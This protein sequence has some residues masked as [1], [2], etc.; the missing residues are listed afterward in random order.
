MFKTRLKE[1]RDDESEG[2]KRQQRW[3]EANKGRM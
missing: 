2:R 1:K 3:L